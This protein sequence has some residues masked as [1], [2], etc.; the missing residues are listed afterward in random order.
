[1]LYGLSE[2]L[3]MI[4]EQGL[5]VIFERH[6]R[7]SAGVRAALRAWG[8]PMQCADESVH[9]PVLT[10]VVTPQGTDADAI[11][12]LIHD[13][14]DLSLGTGLG[15]VKG[16]M[17]RIGHLGDCN[18]LTLMAALTGVEMGL[19]L[20]GVPLAG[21]GVAAAMDHFAAAPL[22]AGG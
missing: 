4:L 8:L 18:D 1:L 19:K 9:S 16:R 20:A 14:F 13:R 22:A 6:Q 15:K 7:W 10:G 3:D 11:R 12:K 2:S 21:S 5:P 17:F